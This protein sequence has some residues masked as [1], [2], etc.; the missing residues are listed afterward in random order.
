MSNISMEELQAN[1]ERI[2]ELGETAE[3]LSG[4]VSDP[5]SASVVF[6]TIAASFLT[7]VADLKGRLASNT[8]MSI[9]ER[10]KEASTAEQESEILRD[11]AARSA[12]LQEQ[13]LG[14]QASLEKVTKERDELRRRLDQATDQSRLQGPLLQDRPT[15][16][17][18]KRKSVESLALGSPGQ[19]TMTP[20]PPSR[21]TLSPVAASFEPSPHL[22]ILG[23]LQLPDRLLQDAGLQQEFE[24]QFTGPL[25]K[26]PQEFD[27]LCN[28][29][30]KNA[31]PLWCLIAFLRAKSAKV[32]QGRLEKCE[33][34]NNKGPTDWL[35]SYLTLLPLQ[36]GEKVDAAG[37]RWQVHLR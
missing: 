10:E 7:E 20:A 37:K 9:D 18:R 29:F 35:C 27:K 26:K 11:E 22:R 6:Q 30:D 15:A 4:V 16:A 34:C 13:V 17:A 36:G 25:I 12:D 21:S 3:R 14:L 19:L 1:F 8:Q 23:M 5:Q 2:I 33:I 28:T 31:G 32:P 24:K